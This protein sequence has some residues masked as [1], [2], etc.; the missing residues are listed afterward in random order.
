MN[1]EDYEVLLIPVPRAMIARCRN[2]L[3]YK[4]SGYVMFGP[5]GG[6]AIH[7]ATIEDA[8]EAN[9]GNHVPRHA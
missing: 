5:D 4:V 7:K 1:P 3:W 6:T 2:D 9:A 8:P